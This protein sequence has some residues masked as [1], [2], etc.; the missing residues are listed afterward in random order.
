MRPPEAGRKGKTPVLNNR[1]FSLVPLF[2]EQEDDQ[3]QSSSCHDRHRLSTP[4]RNPCRLP[5]SQSFTS[6][7]VSFLPAAWCFTSAATVIVASV[8][9]APVA[10]KNLV[11]YNVAKPTAVMNGASALRGVRIIVLVS[12]NTVSA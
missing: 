8:T 12:A 10:E 6:S 3:T 5:H 7:F 11:A 2:K 1:G 9:A 4:S